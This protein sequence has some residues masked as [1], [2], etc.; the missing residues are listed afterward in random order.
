MGR[1]PEGVLQI[2]C[3][4]SV[5]QVMDIPDKFTDKQFNIH[6]LANGFSVPYNGSKSLRT[7]MED[8]PQAI[9]AV[10]EALQACM[11]PPCR[12]SLQC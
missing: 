12:S 5:E 11:N 9:P 4:L 10:S 7:L 8:A 6:L 1:S 3:T 2:S